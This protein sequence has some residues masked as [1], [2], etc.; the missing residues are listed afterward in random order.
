MPPGGALLSDFF[1][2][3]FQWILFQRIC[4]PLVDIGGFVIQWNRQNR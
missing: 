1:R 2:F 3:P 4:N